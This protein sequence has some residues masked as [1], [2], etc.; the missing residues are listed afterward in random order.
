MAKWIGEARAAELAEEDQ[1]DDDITLVGND[2]ASKWKQTTLAVLF[3]GQKE[4][5][6]RLSPAEVDAESVLME[7]LAEAEED[8]RL[9]DG[10]VEIDSDDEFVA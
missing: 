6:S 3:G 5:P 8:G 10:E 2:R 9:D 4:R 1:D 7:A